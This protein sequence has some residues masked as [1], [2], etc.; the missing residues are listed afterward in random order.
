MTSTSKFCMHGL[1]IDEV[2][3]CAQSDESKKI[4][5]KL[6][7][8]YRSFNLQVISISLLQ[9][10]TQLIY[11]RWSIAKVLAFQ[12]SLWNT[13]QILRQSNIRLYFLFNHFITEFLWSAVLVGVAFHYSHTD[14]NKYLDFKIIHYK[15]NMGVTAA[16]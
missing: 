4:W 3:I 6:Q 1:V 13:Y 10:I 11:N 12:T 16:V 9:T 2:W 8:Y 5:R 7:P 14:K 15:S